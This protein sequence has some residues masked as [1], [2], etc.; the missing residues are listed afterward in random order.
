MFS[1]MFNVVDGIFVGRGVGSDALAA[2]NIAAPV[3]MIATGISLMLGSG[4]SVV[5]AVHL[6]KGNVK[7]ANINVTQAFTVGLLL[8][9]ILA[10]VVMLFPEATCR[11]FGGSARLQPYVTA[12]LLNISPSLLC[13]MLLMAGMFVIRLDGAPKFAMAVNVVAALLNIFLDWLFV[14]PLRQGIGGAAIATTISEIVGALMIIWYMTCRSRT[15]RWYKPKFTRTA[16][17]LTVRN[18]GY[19]ARVGFST[20][21]GETAIS[22]TMIVGNYMYIMLLHEDGVAA[23]S[24]AC[25]L[26]PLIFMFGNAIAQSALPII[27]YNH[28]LNNVQRIRQTLHLSVVLAFFSG[29]VLSLLGVFCPTPLISLFL[30]SGSAAHA[31]ATRGFPLFALSFVFFSLNLVLIGYYQSLERARAATAFM[32]LRG[33]IFIIPCFLLL[34]RFMGEQGLWLAI[35]SAEMLTLLCIVLHYCYVKK[36]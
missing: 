31:I 5:A 34:P 30:E 33:Y 18:V 2:V 21:L 3:F 26:V 16:V 7:A 27:S 36:K 8:M 35:P 6:S 24:V 32:L 12:Y 20:F 11:L 9:A 14:F 25:Y 22:C 1:A 28:G 23:F 17:R 4:V 15:L 19:M 13:T 10:V 29:T